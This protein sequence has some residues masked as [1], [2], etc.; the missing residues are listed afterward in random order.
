[1]AA[2]SFGSTLAGSVLFCSGSVAAGASCSDGGGGISSLFCSTS[3]AASDGGGGGVVFLQ[4]L[5]N[6][7]VAAKTN[8]QT[9]AMFFDISLPSKNMKTHSY[10]Q[11]FNIIF[12]TL[13]CQ[14]NARHR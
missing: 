12:F 2:A 8:K 14:A 1:V 11:N 9:F 6:K 4:E 3:G 5:A 10:Y 13:S 7:T